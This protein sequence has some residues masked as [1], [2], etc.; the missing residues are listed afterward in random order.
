MLAEARPEVARRAAIRVKVRNFMFVIGG[1]NWMI[2]NIALW[3]DCEKYGRE[4]SRTM[5]SFWI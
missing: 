5:K 4:D 3:R 1:W 2:D